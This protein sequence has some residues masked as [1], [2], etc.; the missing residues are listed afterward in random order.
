MLHALTTELK[1]D[2]LQDYS[3]VHTSQI[4]DACADLD[5][6]TLLSII[7][8]YTTA[9]DMFTQK[10]LFGRNE[11]IKLLVDLGRA[12]ETPEK[13]DYMFD[14]LEQTDPLY[15]R[16]LVEVFRAYHERSAPALTASA[17]DNSP[18]PAD[19]APD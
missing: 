9:D 16:C 3:K 10:Y 18:A 19:E 1:L 7:K 14:M 11:N 5:T 2:N 13:T 12:V 17:P 6:Q 8:R 4:K 15:V